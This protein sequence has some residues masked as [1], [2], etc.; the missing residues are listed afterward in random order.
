MAARIVAILSVTII[1]LS[2]VTFCLETLPDFKRVRHE[3]V[4][5]GS[6]ATH[7]FNDDDIPSFQVGDR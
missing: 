4:G 7:T 5:E 2:I 3:E 1:L 6:N